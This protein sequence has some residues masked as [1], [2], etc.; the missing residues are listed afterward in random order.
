[1]LE[2][3]EE[4]FVFKKHIQTRSNSSQTVAKFLGLGIWRKFCFIIKLPFYQKQTIT[5]PI[6]TKQRFVIE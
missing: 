6:I 1:M 4:L 3:D 2:K 5:K